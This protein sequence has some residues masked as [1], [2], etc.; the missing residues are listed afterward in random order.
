ML[1]GVSKHIVRDLD[2]KTNILVTDNFHSG[3]MEEWNKVP[4]GCSC[5][6]DAARSFIWK[7]LSGLGSRRTMI[8]NP[9]IKSDME[10]QFDVTVSLLKLLGTGVIHKPTSE[11]NEKCHSIA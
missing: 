3:Q 6:N 9:I 7:Y 4:I 2:N 8:C 10:P 11:S 1:Y 5:K